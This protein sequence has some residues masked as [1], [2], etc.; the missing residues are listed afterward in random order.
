MKQKHKK[1]IEIFKLGTKITIQQT[2]YPC[3][4]VKSSTGWDRRILPGLAIK[5]VSFNPVCANFFYNLLERTG[6]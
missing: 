6:S 2:M 1:K 4:T 5:F 3:F